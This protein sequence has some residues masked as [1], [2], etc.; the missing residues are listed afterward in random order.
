MKHKLFIILRDYLIKF[1]FD[2][3]QNDLV[4][5][6]YILFYNICYGNVLTDENIQLFV[7]KSLIDEICLFYEKIEK[8]VDETKLIEANDRLLKIYQKIQMF[9]F[10]LQ[11]NSILEILFIT[12][13]KCIVSNF[14][15]KKTGNLPKMMSQLNPIDNLLF[16][17]CIEFMYW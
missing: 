13:A 12:I 17:S 9:R 5:N 11:E 15:I 14:F 1:F 10:D 7:Y 4:N 3:E 8:Y 2:Q 6:S 16:D